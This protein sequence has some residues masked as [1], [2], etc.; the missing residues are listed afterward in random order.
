MVT[1]CPHQVLQ[2]YQALLRHY[3][4]QGWWPVCSVD[5][6]TEA[7]SFRP[8]YHPGAYDF[9]RNDAQRLEI[10]LGAILT[11]NT[12]WQNVVTALEALAKAGGLSLEGL[13]CIE[14][15][16]IALVI[17]SAGHYNQKAQYLRNFVD[18]LQ[19]HSFARLLG[20][21]RDPLRRHLLAIKGI[22]PETADCI[23][24]YALGKPSFVVD[25]YTRRIMVA[26]G[27]IPEGIGYEPLREW[28]ESALKPELA[29]Y[30]EYHALLVQHGKH[31]YRK[32]P[33]RRPD[34]VLE[35]FQQS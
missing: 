1:G 3:G 26:L 16:Q 13:R 22:G 5:D 17:K 33:Y 2:I 11:Q 20:M 8:A 35:S 7:G 28:F 14:S 24:L 32:K 34:P 15:A 9:P 18:F 25:A 19:H 10:C 21:A 27:L 6:G 29:L 12:G 23:L 30:Q 4:P 31:G